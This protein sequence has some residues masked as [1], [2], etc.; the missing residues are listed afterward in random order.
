MPTFLVSGG[1]SQSF[2]LIQ[3]SGAEWE[4]SCLPSPLGLIF[5]LSISCIHPK[6]PKSLIHEFENLDSWALMTIQQLERSAAIQ[7]QERFVPG[8]LDPKFSFTAFCNTVLCNCGCVLKV[9]RLP[10]A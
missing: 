2:A 1:N 8:L 5:L 9:E 7:Y 6:T 3:S 4:I 10:F